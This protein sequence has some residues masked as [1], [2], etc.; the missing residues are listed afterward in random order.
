LLRKGRKSLKGT[1]RGQRR[2]GSRRVA[3]SR[4]ESNLEEQRGGNGCGEG[5]RQTYDE[6]RKEKIRTKNMK[7]EKKRKEK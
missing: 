5:G 3:V 2:A 7:K 4:V 6:K 1:S